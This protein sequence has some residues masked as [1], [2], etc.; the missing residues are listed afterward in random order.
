MPSNNIYDKCNQAHTVLSRLEQRLVP[1][2][3]V[4]IERD[5]IGRYTTTL[6]ERTCTAVSIADALAQLLRPVGHPE[7]L[8][9]WQT[10]GVR[11]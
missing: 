4:Q 7:S 2:A 11:K 10:A 3:P 6:G 9:Q 5:R 8:A 1:G